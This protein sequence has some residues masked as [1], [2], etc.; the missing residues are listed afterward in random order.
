MD[1]TLPADLAAYL[2]ELDRF[3]AS[4][5]KPLEEATTTSA[6]STIAANGRA[7]TSRRR[8]AAAEWEACCARREPCGCRRP[9][10]LRDP[11]TLRRQGRL[12][13]LD[14]RD[15]RALCRQGPGP[16]QRF[17]ERAFHRRQSAGRH[18]ARPLRQ[19][20]AEGDDRRLDHGKILHHLRPDRAPARLGRHAY[21]NRAVPATRDN[22]KGWLINGEKMWTT[23]MHVATQCAL[24]A[25]TRRCGDA[26][27]SAASWCRPRARA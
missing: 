27:A 1:F 4:E 25:R 12:Q 10:A 16:A 2:G 15:P 6:S 9:S 21:G 11:E 7:P 8:P 26:R 18:H 17:A 22:I 3:I 20:R 19:R 24:F 13:S 23:G 5:I 14:G